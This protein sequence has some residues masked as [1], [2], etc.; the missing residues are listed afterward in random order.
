MERIDYAVQYDS[1]A[2]IYRRIQSE[3]GF[4]E[5]LERA[6][7]QRLI[8]LL[9]ETARRD[10]LERLRPRLEG[11]EA[12]VVGLAPSA[13]PPPIWTLPPSERPTRILVADGAAQSCLGAGLTPDVIVTDLDG[14]V[15]SEV[16][17]NARGAFALIHAHGDNV[18]AL[19]RW[20]GEFSGELG[21][22]TSGPPHD[23]LLNV[24]GFTDGDRAAFLA[25]H[26]GAAR[27]LLWGF[28][29]NRLDP[30]E[31]DPP[32]KRRKLAW[33]DRL[34]GQLSLQSPVPILRWS[35]DGRRER[36]VALEPGA[37]TQ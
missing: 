28:D 31:E 24:G 2:P 1:W 37:T 32:R 16:L 14:P 33:A 5:E 25:E 17:A 26:L 12:I 36:Y 3:F 30:S 11:S 20:V 8:G 29:A 19:E 27:I 21:G 15:A 34:L 10:P 18:P 7:T 22:S 9:S 35:P 13:G 6:A 23:G 4:P